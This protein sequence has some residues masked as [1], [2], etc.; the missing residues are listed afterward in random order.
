M[1]YHSTSGDPVSSESR[2]TILLMLGST[3]RTARERCLRESKI[4]LVFISLFSPSRRKRVQSNLSSNLH[5]E[6]KGK[7]GS[8]G[9]CLCRGSARSAAWAGRE[10]QDQASWAARLLFVSTA[11]QHSAAQQ[12]ASLQEF[13]RSSFL[14]WDCEKVFCL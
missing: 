4:H 2:S 3:S 12:G 6:T 11:W 8:E 1:P 9:G 13:Q 10:A 14:C 7:K 5:S